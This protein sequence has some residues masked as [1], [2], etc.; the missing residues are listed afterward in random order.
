MSLACAQVASTMFYF[1]EMAEADPTVLEGA[2]YQVEGANHASIDPYAW[3]AQAATGDIGAHRSTADAI[4]LWVLGKNDP[5]PL[6]TLREGLVFARMAAS[7]GDTDDI[8]RLIYMLSYAGMICSLDELDGFAAE[9]L[10]LV[11]VMAGRGH[12]GCATLL[13]S[14]AEHETL[15]TMERAK[16]IKARILTAWGLE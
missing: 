16:E 11:A 9:M 2:D 8:T 15:E 12:E 10:A 3:I 1:P 5:T 13:A 7:R 4:L 6:A 14:V